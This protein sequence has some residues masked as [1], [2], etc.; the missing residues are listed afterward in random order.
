MTLRPPRPINAKPVLALLVDR[1]IADIGAPDI[2]LEDLNDQWSASDFELS[3]DARLVEDADRQ[4]V[5]YAAMGREV[6]IVAVVP[7]DHEG[8]GIGSRLRRWAEQRDRER[9]STCHRQWTA[10]GNKRARALLIDAGY[11]PERSYWRLGRTLDDL[12]K[13]ASPRL[14]VDLRSVDVDQDASPLHTL[15]ELS[16][17]ASPD[18]QPYSF[19][20][21][22]HAH[23]RARAFEP[24]LSCM[25]ESGGHPVGFL[26][27]QRRQDRNLG[28]IDL[29]GVHPANRTRGIATTMLQSAFERFAAAGLR[30]AQLGVASDNPNA[31]R[32][33]ERCGMTK[34]FRYDTYQRPATKFASELAAAAGDPSPAGSNTKIRMATPAEAA[35]L[36]ALQRRSS[37]IWEQYREQLANHPDAIKLPQTFIHNGWVRVAVSDGDLPVGFSVVIPT[38][39]ETDELDGLFV[40]PDDLQR[41]IGRALIEDAV[42]R[43]AARGGRRLEVTAGPAQGFYQRTGFKV[44]GTTQTRFGPAVRMRRDVP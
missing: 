39:S 11:Q 40:E 12:H 18:H 29:L 44:I 22:Y 15:N 21:F 2:T 13:I 3:A 43:A 41:G 23:L 7:L 19:S 25:A 4:V 32:L 1:D 38:D 20:A 28:F 16:F 9:G 14:D 5:G 35:E 8:R 6:T 42:T 30:E 10:A 26:L 24:E 17:S 33:Y 34:R 37:D 31:L 27:A 36:E